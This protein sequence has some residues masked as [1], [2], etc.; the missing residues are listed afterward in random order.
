MTPVFL[1]VALGLVLV[2]GQGQESL[3]VTPLPPGHHPDSHQHE[4][5]HS[6]PYSHHHLP[7]DFHQ[8]YQQDYHQPQQ[9]VKTLPPM[10]YGLPKFQPNI[11]EH[12]NYIEPQL[13]HPVTPAPR[14]ARTSPAPSYSV[15]WGVVPSFLI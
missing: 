12:H 10:F 4:S 1:L 15:P 3:Y 11:Y 2:G 6:V 5:H 13:P 8:D 14:M 9:V 7:H